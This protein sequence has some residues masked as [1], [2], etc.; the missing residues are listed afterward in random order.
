[1]TRSEE[2]IF[3]FFHGMLEKFVMLFYAI[4]CSTEHKHKLRSLKNK[5]IVDQNMTDK[6][7]FE[8]QT[9]LMKLSN[10]MMCKQNL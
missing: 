3:S 8:I 4:S 7:I 9:T 1:M 2:W 6:V 5:T 10:K